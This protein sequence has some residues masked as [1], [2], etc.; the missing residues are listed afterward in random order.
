MDD[1]REVT[2]GTR[3]LVVGEALIDLVAQPGQED[4]TFATRWQ[5][6]TA[7]GPLN[8]AVALA[9][10]GRDVDFAGPLGAD[11]FAAQMVEHLVTNRVGADRAPA[12]DGPT[13]MAVVSLDEAGKAA[14]H[15]HSVGTATFDV[16]V[17]RM[18]RLAGDEWLH[19]AS[20]ALVM[21]PGCEALHQWAVGQSPR[22]LSI[23]LNV[24]TIVEPDPTRYARAIEPWLGLV[25]DRAGLVKGSDEDMDFLAAGVGLSGHQAYAQW[26]VERGVSGVVTTLGPYGARALT[27]AGAVQVPGR[28]V[29]VVDTVAAGDTFMAGFLDSVTEQPDDLRR[30]LHRAVVAAS[31]VVGRR[32]AQP[33]TAAEVADAMGSTTT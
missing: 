11:A 24:R 27:A 25:V 26:L 8:T 19:L 20:L 13:A 21:S 16:H 30:A 10:L 14:Y 18:P 22:Q 2:P 28:T 33:P 5:A 29:E 1:Y 12:G 9:R 32:G 15:F 31:L 4:S 3:F 7:G 17:D 23:D 6:Q